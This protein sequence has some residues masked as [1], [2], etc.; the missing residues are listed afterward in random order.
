MKIEPVEVEG[1]PR[2][3][4]VCDTPGCALGVDGGSWAGHPGVVKAASEELAKLHRSD[5][6]NPDR[7][8][9]STASAALL[10]RDAE[11]PD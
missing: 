9:V 1:N 3:Q 10:I 8:P 6:R 4:A 5:H 2:H 11:L 7:R